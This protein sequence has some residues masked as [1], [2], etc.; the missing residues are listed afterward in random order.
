M[1]FFRNV[2]YQN[3]GRGWLFR[4]TGNIA[5][6][7]RIDVAG[8]VNMDGGFYLPWI[9]S[10]PDV[11]IISGEA[12]IHYEVTS[13][14]MSGIGYGSGSV[15]TDIGFFDVTNRVLSNDSVTPIIDWWA[16]LAW[17][18][19]TAYSEIQRPQTR[20]LR[21][22]VYKPPATLRTAS[23]LMMHIRF[24]NWA[25]GGPVVFS[26]TAVRATVES[27]TLTW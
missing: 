1:G 24:D 15:Y 27:V 3:S 10:Q 6:F 17:P 16:A 11:R 12:R 25:G 9:S 2:A 22:N 4:D 13:L 23:T 21:F 18:I 19:Q 26:E 7:N 14:E 5:I 20:I 8:S